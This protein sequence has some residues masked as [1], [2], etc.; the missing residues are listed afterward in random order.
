[1]SEVPPSTSPATRT[2]PTDDPATAEAR[3]RYAQG[4][5]FFRANH[6]E[7][8]IAEFSEAYSSWQNPTI[9][10][11][12]AQAHERMLHVARAIGYYQQYLA[13]AS[14][15]AAHREETEETVRGLASLLADVRIESNVPAA[16][17]ADDDELGRAPGVVQLSIGRH[18]IELRAEGYVAQ[19]QPITLAARTRREMRFALAAVPPPPREPTRLSPAWFWTSVG[20]T[21]A[22]AITAATL[23]GMTLSAA[24]GYDSNPD[25]TQ[26]ERESGK[27]LATAADVSTGVTLLFGALTVLVGLNTRWS[28]PAARAPSVAV[29]LLPGLAG[30]SVGGSL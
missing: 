2:E 9:L 20:L 17:F 7:E 27:R 19:R 14:P 6:Y 10:Y 28:R 13:T 25:R 1:V 11:S 29:S 26:S 12:L 22:A 30:V 21:G 5:V 18:Q 3:R 16:V 4:A 23:G 15:D 24:G 8:A